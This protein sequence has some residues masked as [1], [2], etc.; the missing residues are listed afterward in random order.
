M[1]PTMAIVTCVFMVCVC[2]TAITLVWI[3]KH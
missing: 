2:V 3:D 1:N